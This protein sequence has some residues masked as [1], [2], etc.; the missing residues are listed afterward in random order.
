MDGK[1]ANIDNAMRLSVVASVSSH[2]CS[3]ARQCGLASRCVSYAQ[4]QRGCECSSLLPRHSFLWTGEP[5]RASLSSDLKGKINAYEY[6]P[7]AIEHFDEKHV[8]KGKKIM[9]DNHIFY[10]ANDGRLRV[11]DADLPSEDVNAITSKR[12]C[13]STNRWGL[14]AQKCWRFVR[15]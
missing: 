7:D 4:A 2:C 13:I 6:T 10:E 14:S 9:D 3:N 1:A 8:I 12:V 5:L 11:N 15:L